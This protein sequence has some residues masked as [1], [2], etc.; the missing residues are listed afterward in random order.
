MAV[1]RPI[2]SVKEVAQYRTIGECGEGEGG[3][4]LPRSLRH[5]HLHLC[6]RLDQK[7]NQR[8]SLVRCYTAGDTQ[9][10]VLATQVRHGRDYRY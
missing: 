9:D 6:S 8:R 3:D 4:K 7:A 5:H 2:G 1:P 10:N